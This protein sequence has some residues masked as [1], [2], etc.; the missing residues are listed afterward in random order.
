MKGYK[1]ISD[2]ITSPDV[3]VTDKLNLIVALPSGGKTHF[4]VNKIPE[5]AG[6]P[7]KVLFLI[8]TT[9]A[10][11]RLQELNEVCTRDD[12]IRFEMDGEEWVGDVPKG[13]MPVMTYAKFA[14][15]LMKYPN[16]TSNFKY[17]ICDELQNLIKYQTFKGNNTSALSLAEKEICRAFGN[18]NIIVIAITAT[19]NSIMKRYH[20][21]FYAVPFDNSE[22]CCYETKQITKYAYLPDLY[23]IFPEG[24]KGIIYTSHVTAVMQIINDMK[25]RGWKAQGFWSVHNEDNPMDD[26]QLRL[27]NEILTTEKIPDDVDL[28]VINAA[29]ETSIKI[30]S[31]VDFIVIHNTNSDE[32]TQVRGRYCG[33]L[34][35][36]F[37]HEQ[38]IKNTTFLWE[39]PPE[40]LDRKLSADDNEKLRSEYPIHYS[41][42]K[43]IGWCIYKIILKN[44]GYDVTE[45]NSHGYNYTVIS[46]KTDSTANI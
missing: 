33:D 45:S 1:H 7:D 15:T 41:N 22:L 40:Y 9:N 37:I 39:M 2:V 35:Q 20:G 46:K 11:N 17:I 38:E 5:W 14:Q 26:S 42:G 18:R 19:P 28:L 16:F 3:F 23:N 32:I 43:A 34:D 21:K 31:H 24:K 36:V 10:E 30:K 29:S 27:R 8:D 44:S 6:S 25:K 4:A 13:Q 12:Y